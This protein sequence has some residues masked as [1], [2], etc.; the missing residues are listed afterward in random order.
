MRTGFRTWAANRVAA[1]LNNERYVGDVLTNKYYVKD[2]MSHKLLK[3][4]G[5]VEQILLSNHY[6]PIVERE[7]FDRVQTI[8]ELKSN[9]HYPYEGFLICPH[10][11]RKLVFR[12]EMLGVKQSAW[13][14]DLDEFYVPTKK[15]EGPV[16][17]AYREAGREEY[18]K[19]ESVEYWWLDE[20]VDSIT[21]GMHEDKDDQ[22]VIVT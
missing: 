4:N 22:T 20:L 10:C 12:P 13:C 14:C 16:L 1:V 9:A 5:E 8:K 19:M 11:G 21:F 7:L 15:L 3:N 17:E 6:T 2:H 18:S